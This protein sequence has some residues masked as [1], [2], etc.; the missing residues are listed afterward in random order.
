[1]ITE[2]MGAHSTNTIVP[3]HGD[4]WELTN[5]DTNAVNL[6][7]YRFDDY[8]GVP[9]N[10]LVITNATVM[11]PGAVFV[12]NQILI[13]P[14]ESVL[15]LSDMTPEA[16]ACWWGERNLPERVQFVRYAGNGF[17]A[18]YDSV[19]LWNPTATQASDYTDRAEY[20]NLNPDF[21]P[22]RGTSLTFWCGGWIEFGQSSV[23]G[24]C[25]A[26]RAA[27]ADDIGSPGYVANHPPRTVVPRPPFCLQVSRD[28]QGVHLTWRT[29]CEMR[30]ELQYKED[31]A[32]LTWTPLSQHSASGP[33]TI[34]TD[35]TSDGRPC[36]F[37]RLVALS[38]PP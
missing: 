24:D 26:V 35:A 29:Q 3:G 37:Y 18:N 2:M 10:A 4:W 9:T 38:D 16:F 25:G 6:R 30:Y 8:G 15:F 17:Q 36:R 5:F 7:G 19:T 23:L 14:G 21:T 31:L 1:M 20:V 12:T 34:T 33:Q 27:E 11:Q 32:A 22:V 28:S 13:Q